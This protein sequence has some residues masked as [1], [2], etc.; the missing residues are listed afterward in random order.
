MPLNSYYFDS[1][2]VVL[3]LLLLLNAPRFAWRSTKIQGLFRKKQ[4]KKVV[5]EKKVEK[6]NR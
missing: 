5:E 2:V 6:Q 3:L 4:A 1:L